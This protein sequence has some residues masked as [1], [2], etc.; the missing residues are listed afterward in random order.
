[1]QLALAIS[2]SDPGQTRVDSETAQINA[3]K[4][5][6]LGRSPSQSLAEFLSLRYWV[7]YTLIVIN[8]NLF[9]LFCIFMF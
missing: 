4:Q 7:K 6:S 1:M 5:I 9:C 3:V 8:S 2:V